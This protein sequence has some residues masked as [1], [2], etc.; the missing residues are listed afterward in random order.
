[1]SWR[2]TSPGHRQTWYLLYWTG[3]IRYSYVKGF[4]LWHPPFMRI[5]LLMQD[6]FIYVVYIYIY[7]YLIPEIIWNVCRVKAGTVCDSRGHS[8]KCYNDCHAE[9]LGQWGRSVT[10]TVF[11]GIE[12]SIMKL[13]D[14]LIFILGIPISCVRFWKYPLKLANV[15]VQF[16]YHLYSDIKD[17]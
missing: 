10:K 13:H 9:P 3:F 4:K 6:Y 12:M 5:W 17:R 1:M 7:I 16:S 15:L 8:G 2:R 14:R 11:P